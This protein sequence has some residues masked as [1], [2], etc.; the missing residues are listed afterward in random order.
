MVHAPDKVTELARLREE[1]R[2]LREAA[3]W[4]K[5]NVPEMECR[6]DEDCDHCEGTSILNALARTEHK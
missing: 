6:M 5:A 4:M 1:N 3:D 2:V